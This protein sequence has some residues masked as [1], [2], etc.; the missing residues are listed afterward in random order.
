[1][2]R[3][4]SIDYVFERVN[5]ITPQ[6]KSRFLGTLTY[7]LTAKAKSQLKQSVVISSRDCDITSFSFFQL[8]SKYAFVHYT[9][10]HKLSCTHLPYGKNSTSQYIP[11]YWWI[12]NRSVTHIVKAELNYHSAGCFRFP[13]FLFFPRMGSFFKF[14]IHGKCDFSFSFACQF[15]MVQVFAD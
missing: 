5:F 15:L 13:T 10:S 9:F 14:E 2:F 1:M 7:A 3:P 4:D 6:K 8:V 11:S 12:G